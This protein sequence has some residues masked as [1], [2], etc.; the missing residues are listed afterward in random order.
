MTRRC[1]D[2]AAG[3]GAVHTM[4]RIVPGEPPAFI[5][6][7]IACHSESAKAVKGSAALDVPRTVKTSDADITMH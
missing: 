2:K 4:P 5:N 1:G 7:P 6:P 3:F